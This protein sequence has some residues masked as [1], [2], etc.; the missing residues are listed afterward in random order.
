MCNVFTAFK[1]I[2]DTHN[3]ME[4]WSVCVYLWGRRAE[5]AGGS[6]DKVSYEQSE[7]RQSEEEETRGTGADDGVHDILVTQTHTH[8]NQ[9]TCQ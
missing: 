5:N 7:T 8:T 6:T 3:K 2:L 9:H 4:W 1:D